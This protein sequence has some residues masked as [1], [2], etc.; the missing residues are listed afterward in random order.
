VEE[1]FHEED[2]PNVKKCKPPR[3]QLLVIE[4]SDSKVKKNTKYDKNLL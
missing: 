2:S 3:S 1:H 4:N